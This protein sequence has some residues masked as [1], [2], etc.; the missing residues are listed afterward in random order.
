MTGHDERRAHLL[1]LVR[2]EAA[3][4]L[5]H[6]S[7]TTM[8]ERGTFKEAGFDSLAAVELRNRINQVTGLRLSGALVYDYPTPVAL[9]DHLLDELV[10][11]TATNGRPA[12]AAVVS[13]EPIA[14]VGMACRLPGGVSTP[15][16]LW[17]MLADGRDAIGGFPTNR[18][19]DLDALYHPDP[20]HFGTSYTRHG[21]FLHDADQFDPNFFG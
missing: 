11:G 12:S 15:E 17:Q 16:H 19:W 20:E 3:T 13:D 14:I 10:G 9:A 5:G 8:P 21:G 18:G 7:T 1:S 4:V 6:G 2:A